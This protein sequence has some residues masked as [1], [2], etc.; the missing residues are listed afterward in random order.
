MEGVEGEIVVTVAFSTPLHRKRLIG[1]VSLS[2]SLSLSLLCSLST[3]SSLSCFHLSLFSLLNSHVHTERGSN[4]HDQEATLHH[5]GA[6]TRSHL[7]IHS[8]SRLLFHISL[9]LIPMHFVCFSN[10]PFFSLSLSLSLPL[11]LPL[12]LRNTSSWDRILS[13]PS[14]TGSFASRISLRTCFLNREETSKGVRMRD[15]S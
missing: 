4:I 8:H 7:P 9:S 14:K 13:P 15:I 11:S 5:T 10:S 1:K 3:F 12:F 2:L 6:L